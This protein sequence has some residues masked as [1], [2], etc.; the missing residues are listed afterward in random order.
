MRHQFSFIAKELL[1]VKNKLGCLPVLSVFFRLFF[2]DGNLVSQFDVVGFNSFNFVDY[3]AFKR[4]EPFIQILDV[5][6]K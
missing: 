1:V 4:V 6:Q 2:S 3:R 5:F